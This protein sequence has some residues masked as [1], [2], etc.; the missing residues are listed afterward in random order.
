MGGPNSTEYDMAG[1]TAV[2]PSSSGDV[3]GGWS[4]PGGNARDDVPVGMGVSN[5]V[6]T[7][8]GPANTPQSA[9]MSGGNDIGG[10]AR[11]GGSQGI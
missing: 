11:D 2:P 10:F 5:P 3:M 6:S 9:P 8:N 7:P 4:R 1:V